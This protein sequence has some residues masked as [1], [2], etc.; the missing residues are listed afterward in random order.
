MCCVCVGICFLVYVFI[1]GN[2]NKL[3]FEVAKIAIFCIHLSRQFATKVVKMCN[4]VIA[5]KPICKA[6]ATFGIKKCYFLAQ[7]YFLSKIL[8][9]AI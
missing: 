4:L 6:F 9:V 3:A 1:L 2:D 7:E 8:F 5:T